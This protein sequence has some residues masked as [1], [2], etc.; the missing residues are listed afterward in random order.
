M[1]QAKPYAR[2][3][4][5]ETKCVRWVFPFSKINAP[6]QRASPP[7]FEKNHTLLFARLHNQTF[8]LFKSSARG[9]AIP[10]PPAPPEV[11]APLPGGNHP[12]NFPA[13]QVSSNERSVSPSTCRRHPP[14]TSAI[15]SSMYWFVKHV[16]VCI[17][18]TFTPWNKCSPIL[19]GGTHE[20]RTHV[21]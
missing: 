7:K 11:I 14:T 9:A 10:L 13:F 17:R 15:H 21:T 12:G 1:Q 3:T 5:L 18:K 20:Y 2:K 16:N 6:T 8:D 4:V 19:K